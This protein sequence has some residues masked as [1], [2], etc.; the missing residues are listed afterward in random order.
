MTRILQ[1]MA[2]TSQ[3][4]D[5]VIAC[6]WHAMAEE[7]GKGGHSRMNSLIFSNIVPSLPQSALAYCDGLH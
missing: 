4:K 7:L 2:T 5:G 3:V 6:E 1:M